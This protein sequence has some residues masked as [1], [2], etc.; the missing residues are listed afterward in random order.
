MPEKNLMCFLKNLEF[1]RYRVSF[2]IVR[3]VLHVSFAWIIK[4]GER[5][6]TCVSRSRRANLRL[7]SC[8]IGPAVS[9]IAT[10]RHEGRKYTRD[11]HGRVWHA[12]DCIKC[13][14]SEKDKEKHG[15]SLI[16]FPISSREISFS[17]SFL[18]KYICVY[19]CVRVMPK[20]YL[21]NLQSHSRKSTF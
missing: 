1:F 13:C 6:F 12:V 15:S 2:E 17:L 21:F 4:R 3:V 10:S 18:H 16:R 8:I 14:S 7:P 20:S 9:P 19:V 5:N 11:A